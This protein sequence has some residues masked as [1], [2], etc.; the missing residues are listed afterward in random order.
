[1]ETIDIET[2]LSFKNNLNLK[3][4][5]SN[6]LKLLI[7][8][9]GVSNRYKK[10]KKNIKKQ[11][12]NILKNYKFQNKKDN[13]VNRINLILNKLSESN[14]NNLVCEFV[15]NINQVNEETFNDILKTIYLKIITEINF[16]NIYIKFLKIIGYIYNKVQNYNLSYFFSI[17]ECKF[18]LDYINLN[19][20]KIIFNGSD[21]DFIKNLN[22]ETYR[23]NNLILINNLVENKL[24]S[25]KIIIECDKIILEQNLFLPDIY[26][27]FNFKNRK[28]DNYE[29]NQIKNHIN[30]ENINQREIVL[31]ESLINQT[32]QP[33][34][35]N[36]ANQ[37]IQS[38][39]IIKTDTINLECDNIIDEY[40]LINSLNDVE[41]FIKNRCNDSI[42][43]NKFC[44]NLINIYFNSNKE[45]A[46]KILV[47]IKELVKSKSIGKINLTKGLLLVN[48]NWK[49]LSIDYNNSYNKMKILLVIFKNM[50]ITKDI[51]KIMTKYKII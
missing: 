16:S 26:Y 9:I 32:N 51:E 23:V 40:I 38:K 37:P 31:L 49:E 15:V 24:I 44:K 19:I 28:L 1:M 14:I 50:G 12:V 25:D 42:S 35:T 22:G 18:K 17:V 6:I 2:F 34:Q 46:D 3:E 29:L 41:Y 48:N 30:K 47:L 45:S 13:I 8:T 10:G 5:D 11:S 39:P 33:I 21:F 27:W 20:Y 7:E 36:Q 4:L 43:K